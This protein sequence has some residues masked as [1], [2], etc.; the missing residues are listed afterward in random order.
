MIPNKVDSPPAAKSQSA[1]GQDPA[2]GL[3]VPTTPKSAFRLP[4]TRRD[5]AEKRVTMSPNMD[6]AATPGPATITSDEKK[7]LDDEKT[8][9]EPPLHSPTPSGPSFGDQPDPPAGIKYS[10]YYRG[11]PEKTYLQTLR[12][13]SGRFSHENWFRIAFRPFVLVFYPSILWSAL[14]YS[15]SIGWLIVLSESVSSIYKNRATYNFDALQ[16]GLVYLSPFIGGV[17]G[18][19]VAGKVSDVVVRLMARFND[20]IY[21]PEFR[22]VMAIPVAITSGTESP[23][24]H[25]RKGVVDVPD[26]EQRIEDAKPDGCIL[27]DTFEQLLAGLLLRGTI[28]SCLRSSLA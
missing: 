11:A 15:L 10:E 2:P 24:A 14:V 6:S 21:E 25:H 7:S 3:T 13:Y 28:G 4:N 8:S 26:A 1:E 18:T 23:L 12:P 5:A 22:L 16:T 17:L 20:G 9:S 27:H 19:A